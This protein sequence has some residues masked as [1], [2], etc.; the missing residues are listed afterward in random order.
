[1]TNDMNEL[2]PRIREKAAQAL[3]TMN[4]DPQLKALGVTSVAP[5]ETL[6]SL[7][8][9]MAYYSRGR[10]P[11]ATD[12]RAMYK[13]AGLYNPTDLECA[14]QITWTL[15]SKHILGLAVD[16]VPQRGGK[17]WWCPPLEVWER[18]G[19]IGEQCGLSWGGRWKNTDS[20]HFEES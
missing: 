8:T 14:T 10:M 13:A 15:E 6:R 11:K 16:F 1:M 4:S 18:M 19:Q 7:P 2:H 3:A 5:N 20:P 9:Q 17:N 12:V